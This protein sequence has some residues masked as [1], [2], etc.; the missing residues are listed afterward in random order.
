MELRIEI[1]QYQNV[2]KSQQPIIYVGSSPMNLTQQVGL[3]NGKDWIDVTD[4]TVN[5]DDLDLGWS[6]ERSGAEQVQSTG[7]YNPKKS[8]SA[9]LIFEAAAYRYIRNWCIDDVAAPMNSIEVRIRDIGCG[10]YEKYMIRSNQIH[11]CETEACD[12]DINLKQSDD[13]YTCIQNTIISDNWQGW[14]Q[15]KPEGGKKH[16]RFSYCNEQRPNGMLTITWWLQAL[17]QVMILPIVFVILGI[18]WIIYNIVGLIISAINAIPGINIP[19]NPNAVPNPFDVGDVFMQMYIES[20]GCGREHPAPLVRDYITNVCDKCGI[21]V[22][23]VSAPIFFA[24]HMDISAASGMKTNVKNPHYNACYM[25]PTFRRGI[26][27]FKTLNVFKSPVKNEDDFYIIENAPLLTLPDF[28]DHLKVIYNAE[29]TIRQGKLFFLRKDMFQN[30]GYLY[31]FTGNSEDIS[32][33]VE[34]VCFEYNENKYPSFVKGLYSK[35]AQDSC[36]DEALAQMNGM[37]S[38]GNIDVNPNFEGVQNKT[39]T[40]FGGTRFRL[41]GAE[42]DYIFDTM[43]VVINGQVLSIFLIPIFRDLDSEMAQYINYCLLM[44]DE[45]STLPKLI[46]WDGE[47]YTNAKAI[48]DVVPVNNSLVPAPSNPTPNNNPKYPKKIDAASNLPVYIPWQNE[49]PAHTDIKGG[50]LAGGSAEE[51]VYEVRDFF[52]AQVAH[53]AARL[54]NYPLYFEPYYENT[55]WDWFHWIDD[56]LLNPKLNMTWTVK[57]EMCCEDLHK[58]RCF[59]DGSNI[60]LLEKVKLPTKYYQ[61]GVITEIHVSY[62]SSENVGKYISLRGYV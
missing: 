40:N 18:V 3:V 44:K 31:D 54:V 23:H 14:F 57:I 26:R 10:D 56:P 22:D 53:A 59:G 8:S 5:L 29:W 58:I 13:P 15:Y 17:L 12:F 28:L 61:D 52:G 2:N 25:T 1:R 60:A 42:T 21:K 9:T 55:L 45:V 37:V 16:P 35:D 6:I 48:R 46:I 41:D 43:Q 4:D 49:H 34:G 32:K 20:A 33:I 36:A 27:R 51:G 30:G 50:A 62:K 38:Y 19:W 24:E 39:T 47:S 7:A 11:W